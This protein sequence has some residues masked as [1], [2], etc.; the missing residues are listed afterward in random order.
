M[1]VI[2]SFFFIIAV[3]TSSY[4]QAVV[5]DLYVSRKAKG[6]IYF[7]PA[8]SSSTY[9]VFGYVSKVVPSRDEIRKEGDRIRSIVNKC[10]DDV[11]KNQGNLLK[12]FNMAGEEAAKV[13]SKESPA[14]L[15]VL[16]PPTLVKETV[17]L[18]LKGAMLYVKA[19]PEASRE[20]LGN[21]GETGV[22]IVNPWGEITKV[23]LGINAPVLCIDIAKDGERAV[24]LT[25]MSFEDKDEN[26]HLLGEISLIDLVDKKRVRSWIFANLGDSVRFVPGT[27]MIAFDCYADLRNFA[28]REVRFI[29]LKSGKIAK[30]QYQFKNHGSGIVFGKKIHYSGF[31]V[32][33][34]EPV[35]GLYQGA[36]Y[37][38]RNILT[39]NLLFRVKS[40]GYFLCFSEKHP[41]LFTDLGKIVD[42]KTGKLIAQVRPRLNGSLLPLTEARFISDD[43]RIVYL[44]G[45]FLTLFDIRSGKPIVNTARIQDRGGIFIVSPDE[46]YLAAFISAGGL[47]SYKKKYLKRQRMCLNII[48]L[49]S[50]RGL[51][52]ICLPDSTVVDAALAGK[53]LIV[54]GFDSLRIYVSAE[55]KKEND[56]FRES[57]KK[58]I[59]LQI[60]KDPCKFAG[61]I[62]DIDGWAW[63]WMAKAPEALKGKSI[64][65]A[66]G[67]YGSRSDGTFTDG[68]VYVL[69][70]VPVNFSGR[71]HL[72]AK[73]VI[74]PDGWQLV[75]VKQD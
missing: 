68:V 44:E 14:W 63:G 71:F 65:F 20:P 4:S 61:K 45:N 47:V 51:Q 75:P 57:E 62:I 50:L 52:Q 66:R 59:L 67:N 32:S 28:K 39:G 53:S 35:I 13:I 30:Y 73:V 16:L 15:K 10:I 34:Y 49:K 6:A 70:P 64:P 31:V 11:G 12:Q 56:F 37:E 9:A 29:D 41:W 38:I 43:S 3:F 69:Y 36:A 55:E 74:T 27:D 46:K 26:L 7:T 72:K 2:L 18:L 8:T 24:V 54:S 42:Y 1:R 5:L 48:D 25:D 21:V 22:I 33:D 40:G 17:P 60:E 58:S 23:P 19:H